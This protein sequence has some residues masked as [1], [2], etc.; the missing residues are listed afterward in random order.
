[1][2]T[3]LRFA[4]ININKMKSLTKQAALEDFIIQAS[5]DIVFLQECGQMNFNFSPTIRVHNNANFQSTGTALLTR[6]KVPLTN[7][8]CHPNNRI[9]SAKVANV[10]I[11]NI[12]APSGS[13][14]RKQ[15]DEFFAQEVAV[16]MQGRREHI[17]CGGDFNCVLYPQDQRPG[18]NTS[19]SLQKLVTGFNFTDVWS[20]KCFGQRGFTYIRDN[21]ASRLDRFYVTPTLRPS[22]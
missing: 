2:M 1:M 11:Y 21:C 17:I 19:N 18:F 10:W 5:L 7:V 22:V 9:I 8:V 3:T 15:R 12:Y 20:D 6:N 16:E 4:T 13:Q 14:C